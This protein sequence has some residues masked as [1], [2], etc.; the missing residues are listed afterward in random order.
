[1]E[2]GAV[3][4]L[5][6]DVLGCGE[7]RLAEP[8]GPFAAHLGEAIHVAIHELGQEVAA[9]ARHAAAALRQMGGAAVRAAG[10]EIGCARQGRLG[11]GLGLKRL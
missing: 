10:A 8:T 4:H 9:D 5:L 1:M 3:A 2:V 6:E 7:G 11:S